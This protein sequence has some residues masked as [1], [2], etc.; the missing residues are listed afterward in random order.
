MLSTKATYALA[1]LAGLAIGFIAPE[2][3]G[4]TNAI[5][6]PE[7]YR[8]FSGGWQTFGLIL[9]EWLVVRVPAYGLL[10]ALAVVVLMRSGSGAWLKLC[11]IVIAAELIVSFWVLPTLYGMTPPMRMLPEVWA[12]HLAAL[13]PGVLIAGFLEG[14]RQ[15]HSA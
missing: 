3:L 14:G 8:E 5:T 12:F 13:L 4:Y 10:G 9:W 15:P 6:L 11:L 2:I 7:F 1:V